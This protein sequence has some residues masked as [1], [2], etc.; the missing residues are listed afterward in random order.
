[1]NGFIRRIGKRIPCLSGSRV[2]ALYVEWERDED[3]PGVLAALREQ[4]VLLLEA[5]GDVDLEDYPQP[6]GKYARTVLRLRVP[7]SVPPWAVLSAAAC[8]PAVHAV[9]GTGC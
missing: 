3:I 9:S 6:G 4:R 5:D 1:M 8:H 2:Q 7:R